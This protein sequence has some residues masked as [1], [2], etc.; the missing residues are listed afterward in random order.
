MQNYLKNM[1]DYFIHLTEDLMPQN[2]C[3]WS[4]VMISL[5]NQM[6]EN[7]RS[8][9]TKCWC[10]QSSPLIVVSGLLTLRWLKTVNQ[11]AAQSSRGCK[12]SV[13]GDW[14][15]FRARY[16]S[17]ALLSLNEHRKIIEVFSLSGTNLVLF[18]YICKRARK[19]LHVP[20]P[21]NPGTLHQMQKALLYQWCSSPKPHWCYHTLLSVFLPNFSQNKHKIFLDKKASGSHIRFPITISRNMP[22]LQLPLIVLGIL[23]IPS[24]SLIFLKGT[25]TAPITTS[26]QNSATEAHTA[27][28]C[29]SRAG[30]WGGSIATSTT[31]KH[32]PRKR[33]N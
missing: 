33:K 27:Q 2:P 18:Y 6:W 1:E 20:D 30:K 23:H 14:F 15:F 26:L 16:H 8:E 29:V 3:Y 22:A 31:Q 28:L 13:R 25:Y 17:E 24:N 11:T 32:L 9:S 7:D 21:F 5:W 12:S 19:S 10:C 4:R